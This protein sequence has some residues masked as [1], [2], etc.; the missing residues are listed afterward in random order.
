[1]TSP[2]RTPEAVSQAAIFLREDLPGARNTSTLACSSATLGQARQKGALTMKIRTF[3]LPLAC[4]ALLISSALPIAGQ[5]LITF[6]DISIPTNDFTTLTSIT[7]GYQGLNWSNCFA[8]NVPYQTS[9][10][11]VTNGAN[12]GMISPPNIAFNGSG[13]PAEID[14]SGTNFNF[15]SVY[16]TGI[17]NNNL[18]IEV[19]GFGGTNLLYDQSVVASAT[20]PTLFTFNYLGIDRLTFDSFGGEP[21][22]FSG[23]SGEQ[24]AMDNLSVEFIPEPASF[25][26]AALGGVSLVAFLRRKRL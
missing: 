17:W 16:L 4:C 15:L 18:N 8:A 7:N 23:G 9:L 19:E 10:F 3:M 12:Y 6:D 1:M 5:T 13:N 20:S 26:L 11:G 22:G 2:L 21:A 25:L 14:S 24:F